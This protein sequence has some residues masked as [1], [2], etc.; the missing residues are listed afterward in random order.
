MQ[1]LP[2]GDKAQDSP[3]GT[4]RGQACPV[5]RLLMSLLLQV[6]LFKECMEAAQEQV[7]QWLL[8]KYNLVLPSLEFLSFFSVQILRLKYLQRCARLTIYGSVG[9]ACGQPSTRLDFGS[10]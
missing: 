6:L 5:N 3:L 2:L 7:P 1:R 9:I 4:H 10:T 8:T